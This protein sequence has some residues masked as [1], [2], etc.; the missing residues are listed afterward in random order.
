MALQQLSIADFRN[1]KDATLE[2]DSNINL[3]VGRNAAGKTSLL[4]A[5]S[6]IV[7]GKSFRSRQ[8]TTCIRKDRESF[9]LFARNHGHRCGFRYSPKKREL[10][11]DGKNVHRIRELAQITAA[12]VMDHRSVDL[13]TGPPGTRRQF[14]DWL[15]FHVKPSYADIWSRAQSILKQ[16]NAILRQ[17]KDLDML[18]YWDPLL[19][20][21]TERVHRER[22]SVLNSLLDKDF[23]YRIEYRKG[24][25]DD[26]G[27]QI[28]RSRDTDIR[29]GFTRYGFTRADLKIT[30]QGLPVTESA[31]RGQLKS[32]SIELQ[33]RSAELIKKEAEKPCIV[34]IDDLQAELDEQNLSKLYTRLLSLDLQL[35]VTGLTM[36][37]FT[38]ALKEGGRMF[39]V[40]HGMISHNPA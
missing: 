7:Q 35:F 19:V 15:V 5:L 24:F 34:L 3:I 23:G 40:E 30:H 16:R 10:R 27:K 36:D 4:E 1:L 31:S 12:V 13:V 38:G 32:L 21:Q 6:V 39:H 26:Y 17:R 9:L 22:L 2:F 8:L 20:E 14:I 18:D 29:Q 28:T 37:A 33:T 25:D 11:I